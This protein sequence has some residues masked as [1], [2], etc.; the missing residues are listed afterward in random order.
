MTTEEKNEILAK[1]SLLL[2]E[3]IDKPVQQK[4]SEPCEMLTIKECARVVKGLSEHTIRLLV[5]RGEIASIRTGEGKSGKILVPK[6]SLLKYLGKLE[7]MI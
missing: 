2:D 4:D 1:I 3:K 6:A 5:R 7:E